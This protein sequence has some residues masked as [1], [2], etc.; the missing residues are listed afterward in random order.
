MTMLG[1]IVQSDRL[2]GVKF[3]YVSGVRNEQGRPTEYKVEHDVGRWKAE[4]WL[5]YGA[6]QRVT[7]DDVL[8][9]YEGRLDEERRKTR[10]VSLLVGKKVPK[11]DP[12]KHLG[13][14]AQ[15]LS[16][17]YRH[18]DGSI[19]YIT[20]DP[21]PGD[22]ESPRTYHGNVATLIQT[23]TR[24][25]EVDDDD[26]GLTEACER[27][28]W[29]G[30]PDRDGYLKRYLAIFRPDILHF[31]PHWS[32][33][34]SYGWGY[35][36]RESWEQA[37]GEDYD[38]EVTPEQ[39]FD[40]EV[41]VYGQWANGEV[42]VSCHVAKRNSEPEFCHGH[43]GYDDHRDIAAQYTDSPILEVLA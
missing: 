9:H 36:T 18:E 26:A 3:G 15:Y 14:L 42:Y 5:P 39:A 4:S 10:A 29:A 2:H 12:R 1:A 31:D 22:T 8:R 41:R 23:N 7:L 35:V 17:A 30:N 37:M 11:F 33:G 24:C 25:I 6:L 43:L 28:V 27:W 20:G 34:D 40:Q 21:M 16:D 32:A 19:T 38:G 13:G